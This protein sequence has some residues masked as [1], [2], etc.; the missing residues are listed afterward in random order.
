MI[1]ALTFAAYA[2]TLDGKT[3]LPH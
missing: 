3:V 2:V 1:H